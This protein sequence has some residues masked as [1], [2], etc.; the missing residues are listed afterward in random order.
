MRAGCAFPQH[1]GVCPRKLT[2]ESSI[3]D[4]SGIPYPIN[5]CAN[6]NMVRCPQYRS[7]A[8]SG[9]PDLHFHWKGPVWQKQN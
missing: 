2:K 3:K 8:G 6:I 5:A 1:L 9:A 7:V 4:N